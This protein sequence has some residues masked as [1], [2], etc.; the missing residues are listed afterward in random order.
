MKRSS[1]HTAGERGF[2]FVEVLAVVLLLGVLTLVALPN[3]F[4]AE[5]QAKEAVAKAN[6]RAVNAALA[7]YKFQNNGACPADSTAFTA[8]LGNT[9]YFPDGT[10]TMPS[11][12]ALTYTAGTCRAAASSS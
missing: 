8:F 2:T 10:P 5:A 7:L 11:G 4:G 6:A 1:R 9:A 3:Y 12:W